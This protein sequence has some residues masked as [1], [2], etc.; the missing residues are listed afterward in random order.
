MDV[1]GFWTVVES[2]RAR[3]GNDWTMVS[4]HVVEALA[5][6]PRD[7]IADFAQIQDALEFEAY[8]ED[9]WTACRL[10]NGGFGSDDTF[11]YFRDWLLVQG[12]EV[13][14]ATLLNPDSL[15]SL[16][17]ACAITATD[18]DLADCESFLY[19]SGDAWKRITGQE[20]GLEDELDER[21]FEPHRD[22]PIEAAGEPI[23]FSDRA[24]VQAVLP[25]LTELFYDR[26]AAYRRMISL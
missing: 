25:R 17:A 24:Q 11:L 23:D 19:V 13:W 16:P 6:L 7:E 26:A 20:Y 12:R 9:L 4:G 14:H 8:R 18:D 3:C 2:A 22:A 21:G 10:I 1:D 15:A 5:E